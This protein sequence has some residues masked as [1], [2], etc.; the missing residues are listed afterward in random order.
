M[1]LERE[2]ELSFEPPQKSTYSDPSVM[3]AQ[4]L[5]CSTLVLHVEKSA[6][7]L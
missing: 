3:K 7:S 1:L 6:R 5:S 4:K 2:P